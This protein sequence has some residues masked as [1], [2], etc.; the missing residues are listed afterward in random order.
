MSS[1]EQPLVLCLEDREATITYFA[2]QARNAGCEPEIFGTPGELASYL[3]ER[4]GDPPDSGKLAR[5]RLGFIVD[6]M[7]LGV[8]DLGAIGMPQ[9][10]TRGGV[11]AGYVFVDRF[12]RDA[13]SDYRGF[14][15]CFLTE[16]PLTSDLD[17]DI[18]ALQNR[19]HGFLTIVN[20]YSEEDRGKFGEFLS[21]I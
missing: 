18:T 20:K 1:H 10:S 14:P 12:L 7:I 8:V 3:E 19:N 5:V 16:R 13:R 6:L 11:H 9:V 2:K 21:K 15:V 4:F 17:Q